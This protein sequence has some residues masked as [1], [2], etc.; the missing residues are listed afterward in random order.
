MSESGPPSNHPS[1]AAVLVQRIRSDRKELL[2]ELAA[3][4]S[5]IFPGVQIDRTLLRRQVTAIRLPIG[6]YT[7]LLKKGA[8][9]SFEPSRLQE[10]RGVVIRTV[11]MEIDAFLQELGMALDAELQRTEQ[12]RA[13]LQ[14]WL[15]SWDR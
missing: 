9:D 5:A 14:N 1:V 15:N 11:P 3:L 10:V 13:A 4:L 6:G 7:Y 12:G 2:D 8:D